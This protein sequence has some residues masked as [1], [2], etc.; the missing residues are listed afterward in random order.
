[1]NLDEIKELI[2]A[3]SASDVAELELETD[4]VR[5][6]LKKAIVSGA[7]Y[8]QRTEE[9]FPRQPVTGQVVS[10]EAPEVKEETVIIAAPMVG[11]FYR[12]P[13][14]DAAPYV[15]VGDRIEEGQ[16]LCIIEAMKMMNEIEADVAG[17]I[18]EILV[19][20]AQP[21]EYGQ[22]LFVVEKLG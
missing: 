22:P 12:A 16:P 5:L 11:V 6:Y 21:V 10:V 15:E 18:K 7:P 4:K 19:D 3:L 13:A 8:E 17:V 14:P 1:M 2:Q 9:A 20:N